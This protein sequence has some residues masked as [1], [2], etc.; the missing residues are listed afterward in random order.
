MNESKKISVTVPIEE[1]FE[2]MRRD[3]CKSVEEALTELLME[4]SDVDE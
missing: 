3:E 2:V 1:V 4:Y